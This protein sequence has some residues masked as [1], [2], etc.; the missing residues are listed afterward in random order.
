MKKTN[1]YASPANRRFIFPGPGN[2]RC[3]K[4]NKFVVFLHRRLKAKFTWEPYK[5]PSF[6]TKPNTRFST[7]FNNRG[8]HHNA[9]RSLKMTSTGLFGSVFTV[10]FQS[11]YRTEIH[12]NDVFLFFKNHFEISTSKWSKNIKT[13]SFKMNFFPSNFDQ[14]PVGSQYQTWSYSLESTN[15]ELGVVIGILI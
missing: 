3:K 13:Y 6:V 4:S 5:K 9:K 11:A 8:S 15:N 12:Q 1:S 14:K 7:P 2:L 10:A